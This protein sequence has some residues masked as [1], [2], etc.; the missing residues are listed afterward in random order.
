MHV[1][2][3]VSDAKIAGVGFISIVI[4]TT[5]DS[6]HPQKKKKKNEIKNT[7]DTIGT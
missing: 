2:I 4:P 7:T 6:P 1:T 5:S 3:H